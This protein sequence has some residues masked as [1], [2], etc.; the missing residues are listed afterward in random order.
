MSI[1]RSPVLPRRPCSLLAVAAAPAALFVAALGMALPAAG[2]PQQGDEEPSVSRA[3]EGGI[4]G[5]LERA[6]LT[7][8]RLLDVGRALSAWARDSRLERGGERARRQR[9]RERFEEQRWERCPTIGWSELEALLVPAYLR[10]L[11]KED[12]WGRPLEFC[13]DRRFVASRQRYGVR[14]AG[15]DG[16]FE[17][18]PYRIGAFPETRLESDL[19]W[20]DGSFVRW[21]EPQ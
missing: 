3:A 6:D 7:V 11:P 12:G 10:E 13:L 15:S 4:D 1:E 17:A 21:H 8:E 14:S 16:E 5:D 19:V 9:A 18:D 20:M 2:L